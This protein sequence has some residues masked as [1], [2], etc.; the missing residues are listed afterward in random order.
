VLAHALA[1][2]AQT[3]DVP[4]SPTRAAHEFTTI[5]AACGRSDGS[6][7]VT[8]PAD[9]AIVLVTSDGTACQ[10]GRRGT[11]PGEYQHPGGCYALRGDTILVL[12]RVL[13]RFVV[14][15]PRDKLTSLSYPPSLGSGWYEP[16]G[17]DERGR[18]V[19]QGQA[20]DGRAPALAWDRA[21]G[22]VDTV[23][24]FE[25]GTPRRVSLGGISAQRD[26]PFTPRA[27]AVAGLAL[28][29]A[30]VTP[31]PFRAAVWRDGVL[32]TG[33]PMPWTPVAVDDG[34]IERY[35]ASQAPPTN[36]VARGSDGRMVTVPQQRWT[37][38]N[39][40]LKRSDIPSRKPAF[41]PEG[42]FASPS[43]ALWIRMH[44]PS[45]ERSERLEIHEPHGRRGS[46]VT[47]PPGRRLVGLGP[48]E[49]FMAFTNADGVQF[50]ERVPVKP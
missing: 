17:V 33:D 31:E 23:F 12:D 49:A 7:I 35:I 26:I 1:A 15:A 14:V 42:L 38:E 10:L 5:V 6:V 2:Q 40:G 32:K 36:T 20:T 44:R 19:L 46:P 47:L 11:G 45:V 50:L 30:F 13:R 4:Q 8:D 18:V 34:D 41:D 21:G 39:F 22:A 3:R 9:H 27:G 43:G 25:T 16:L 48:G 29:I 28:G 24:T 37:L